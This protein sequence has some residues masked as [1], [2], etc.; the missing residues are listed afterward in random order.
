MNARETLALSEAPHLSRLR[1]DKE[2]ENKHIFKMV[3]KDV[4]THIY[5]E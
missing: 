2:S 5:E 4:Y 1:K 3:L